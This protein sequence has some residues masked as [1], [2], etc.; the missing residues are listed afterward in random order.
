[1]VISRAHVEAV[2]DPRKLTTNEILRAT[3]ACD[4]VRAAARIRACS[5]R[6]RDAGRRGDSDAECPKTIAIRGWARLDR[7]EQHSSAGNGRA[8]DVLDSR[9]LVLLLAT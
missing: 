5:G 8:G 6:R 4:F 3:D 1:M 9:A 2:A 7:V